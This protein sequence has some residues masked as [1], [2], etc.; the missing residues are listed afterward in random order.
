MSREK[1]IEGKK[2]EREK[3]K[4]GRES[5]TLHPCRAC[6]HS[7]VG[8]K[9]KK[10]REWKEARGVRECSLHALVGLLAERERERERE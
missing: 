5:S 9:R 1:K 8:K 6:I 2:Q 3:G 10:R 4:G 7:I